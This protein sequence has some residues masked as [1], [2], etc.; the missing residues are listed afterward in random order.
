MILKLRLYYISLVRNNSRFQRQTDIFFMSV[1]D[2]GEMNSTFQL[3]NGG[4]SN[5]RINVDN[6]V[7]CSGFGPLE[8]NVTELE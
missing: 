3:R 7:A 5:V 6:L 8:R 1:S 4:R 2:E